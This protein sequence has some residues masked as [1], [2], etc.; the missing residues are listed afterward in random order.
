VSDE[1]FATQEV[2]LRKEYKCVL[3]PKTPVLYLLFINGVAEATKFQS[4]NVWFCVTHTPINAGITCG[5][6]NA[7]ITCGMV[8]H[9]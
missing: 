1:F 3:Y 8:L 7:G 6:V 9:K 5:M 4:Q 2:R